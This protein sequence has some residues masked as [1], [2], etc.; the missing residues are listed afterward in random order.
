MF[1][2]RIVHIAPTPL[3]GAPGKI[4]WAQRMNGHEAISVALSDYPKGG[5]LEKKFLD[6]TLLLDDFT[7]SFIEDS[8]KSADI[9]HV[10][11]FVPGHHVDWLR[12]LGQCATFVY[13][14]HSPL[15]EGPLYVGRAD[16]DVPFDF[17]L[18]LVV[19]QHHGRFY[20]DFIAVPN[21]ILS[22][23]SIRPRAKGDR[24]RVMFSPTQKQQGRWNSKYSEHLETVLQSLSKIGKIDVVAPT[25]PVAPETLMNVRRSC[26][27]TID[28]IATGGFHMV[29]QE[30]LCAGNVVIN[31]ADF[32]GKA[33]FASFCNG[34][35]PPFVYADD[36]TIADT[37]LR[38]AEN[39][40]ETVH[41]QK[42]S[43][44]F[45][46]LFC[47]PL[48]LVEVYDAAYQRI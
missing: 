35:H 5:P 16:N 46:R 48:R 29:S 6:R 1:A 44:E 4:A 25:A 38:L 32:F 12:T 39:W 34:E 14:A 9:V 23:P 3:V 18:K 30:G 8:L 47:D 43:Y 45:F 26:H 17:R 10:H 22:P 42:K 11:N 20:P 7:R 40:E 36:L 27:V 2:R 13:Q 37:L 31:R 41:L 15:R 21:L 24:L 19:G 33:T 28:E